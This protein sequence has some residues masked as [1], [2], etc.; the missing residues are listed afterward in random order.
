MSVSVMAVNFSAGGVYYST[1]SENTVQ[2]VAP[3]EG[4]YTGA[5]VIPQQVIY[6]AVVY[7][8]TAIGKDAFQG[9]TKLTSV[10]LPMK[11]I[12]SIGPYAFNDCTGLTEFTLPASITS[13]G[14]KAFYYCDKLHDLYVHAPDP[15]SYHAG[16]LAF[17]RIHYGS[18]VCTLRRC[19]K[20]RKRDFQSLQQFNLSCH[21][22]KLH[23]HRRTCF[24]G[25]FR[26]EGNHQL[27][28]QSTSIIGRICFPKSGPCKLYV[29]TS[30][31]EAYKA[32]DIWKDFDI[33]AKDIATRT[34]DVQG[35]QEQSTKYIKDGQLFILRGGKVFNAL[36]NCVSR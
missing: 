25:M 17:A 32:A 2:V 8:V 27:C 26:I 4:K 16:N 18:N 9:A 12:T 21:S 23:K 3:T 10:T 30:A 24:L 29:N 22:R 19:H 1:L 6:N 15:A 36:G 34:D 31:E 28:P 5:V 33:E 20:P 35:N 11:G 7:T 13:I 14:E